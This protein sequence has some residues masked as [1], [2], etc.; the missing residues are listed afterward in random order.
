MSGFKCFLVLQYCL[1]VFQHVYPVTTAFNI[2]VPL[3]LGREPTAPICC[4]FSAVPF[5]MALSFHCLTQ[6][7]SKK[8]VSQSYCLPYSSMYLP[9]SLISPFPPLL[10]DS[11]MSSL[12]SGYLGRPTFM[13]SCAG[14]ERTLRTRTAPAFSSF[15]T[16]CGDLSPCKHTKSTQIYS[17]NVSSALSSSSF[18]DSVP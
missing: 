15:V 1:Q 7:R 14:K 5:I 6:G 8:T 4:I 12:L 10:F 18:D 11:L 9:L 2:I 13:S 16:T 17:D 3:L